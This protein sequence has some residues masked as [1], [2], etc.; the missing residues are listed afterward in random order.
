MSTAACL[1]H[2]QDLF[3]PPGDPDPTRTIPGHPGKEALSVM[4][5]TLM[6]IVTPAQVLATLGEDTSDNKSDAGAGP[7]SALELRNRLF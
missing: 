3:D 1:E 7:L 4:T 6:G 2:I 5:T